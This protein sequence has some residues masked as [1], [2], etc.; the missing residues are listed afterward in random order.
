MMEPQIERPIPTPAGF[1]VTTDS[2]IR[3]P[4][5][6]SDARPRVAYRDEQ[7]LRRAQFRAD[8]QFAS[9]VIGAGHGLYR[10]HDQIE[11]DLLQLNSISLNQ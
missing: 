6:R 10:V 2:K 1:V 3:S 7:A 11:H 4:I 9:V 8:H 5:L